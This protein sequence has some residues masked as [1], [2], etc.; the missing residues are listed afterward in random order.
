MKKTLYIFISVIAVIASLA[1]CDGDYP[2]DGDGLLITTRAEC[3]VGNFAMI[4]TDNQDVKIG[5]AYIDTTA[6]VVVA[7]VPYGASITNVWPQ[8]TLCEDAKL[9][10]KITGRR[11]FSPSFMYFDFKGAD[12]TTSTFEALGAEIVANVDSYPQHP[13]QYTVIS[14]NR[15]VKKTYTFLIVQRPLM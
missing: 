6:Q 3:Y 8:V 13:V 7:C 10:P 5:N 2:M 15:K 4:G 9:S 14:G 11:D 1:S 12:W